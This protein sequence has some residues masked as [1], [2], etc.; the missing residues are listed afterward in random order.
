M[1]SNTKIIHPRTLPILSTAAGNPTEVFELPAS[2]T[3]RTSE[4]QIKFGDPTFDPVKS[5]VFEGLVTPDKTPVDAK[6]GKKEG[7][8]GVERLKGDYEGRGYGEVEGEDDLRVQPLAV[9][10]RYTAYQP[11]GQ[12]QSVDSAMGSGDG[13]GGSAIVGTERKDDES[14][15]GEKGDGYDSEEVDFT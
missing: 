1:P 13:A 7:E 10:R 14:L 3:P 2:V 12:A 15:T 4:P 6:E 5:G 11:G 9:Q 8:K